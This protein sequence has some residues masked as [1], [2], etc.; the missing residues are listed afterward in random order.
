VSQ[1]ADDTLIVTR[2]DTASV[3]RLRSLLDNFANATGLN[4]NYSKSSV[5]PLHA[6]P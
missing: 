4:I 1:Y 3:S 5:M 2:A 6:D